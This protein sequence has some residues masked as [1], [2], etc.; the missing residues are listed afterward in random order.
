MKRNQFGR[1]I[2]LAI[3]L[4]LALCAFAPVSYADGA[5]RVLYSSEVTTLNYLI[6]TTTSEF[7]LAANFIDTLIEYDQ[8]GV[9]KE[10]LAESWE[11]SE[12]SLTWTFHLR[13]GAQWVDGSGN[14]VAEVTSA[15]FVAAAKYILNAQN[16]SSSANVL[17]E[18]IE[19]ARAYYDGTSTPEEGAE[20]APVMEWDTVGITAPDAYTVQY[21]LIDPVPY[22]LSM[23]TYVCF[24]PVYEPFLL[25]QG[26]SFG[27]ATGNDTLLYNGA[28]YL[29]EFKPN[30]KRALTRNDTNWDA[31]NIFIESIQ[32]TFNKEAPTVAPELFLRGE[33]DEASLDS[34]VAAEWLADPEKADLIRPIRQSDFYSY[35]YGFN[36]NP[37]FDEI[38]EPENWKLAANNENFRKAIFYGM[39]RYGSQ[40]VFEPSNPESIIFNTITPPEFVSL[41]GLDYT[42]VGALAPIT[43]LGLDTFNEEKAIEHRDA[44]K[45]ELEAAGATFPIKALMPYLPTSSSWADECVVVEQH[46]ESLLGADFIDVIVFAG[47]S[48]GFLNETRRKGNYALQKLNWGPDYADPVTFADPFDY[49]NNYNFMDKGLTQSDENGP[50]VDQYYALVDK[51][52]AIVGDTAARYEAFAEAEAFFIDHAIVIPL[53]YEAA[54]YIGTRINPFEA[55]YAPFGISNYRF[56]G[57]QLLDKPMSTDEYFDAYD[58]WLE[59]REALTAE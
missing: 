33:V 11:L 35:F 2:A 44:A 16:A 9:I 23:T 10:G 42:R 3:C 31:G 54:G 21:K 37:T 7:R 15:D 52:R 39:D 1:A 29:S 49:G 58:A 12:D 18:V 38:Y 50:I 6:T 55:Q 14:P 47:P 22:F 32:Y 25:E 51:A 43:A 26:A 24:M 13:Q 4:T 8:Y 27:L 36:F 59:A 41:D 48:S 19:G 30:E 45:A 20:P 5:Y 40:S 28:Y 34:A 53:G 46:L 57:Q 17:Y 56:K